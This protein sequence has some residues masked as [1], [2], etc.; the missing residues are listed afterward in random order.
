MVVIKNT[1]DL[2]FG[3]TVAGDMASK[4]TTVSVNYDKAGFNE[5]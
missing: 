2:I 1:G 4:N 5:G 3:K